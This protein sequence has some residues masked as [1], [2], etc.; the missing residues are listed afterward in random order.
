MRTII[1]AINIFFL[2]IGLSAFSQTEISYLT[3][4]DAIRI[5]H[6]QSPDALSARQ[7]L[8][9]SYWDYRS[10][11]ASN[12]PALTFNST[13]PYLNQTVSAQ[14]IDG[15]QSYASYKYSMANADLSLTQ[16]IGITGGSVSIKSGL[17][18]Q[19]NADKPNPTPYLSNPINIV[20]NQP[21]FTYNSFR[22]DRKIKPLK[23]SIAQKK[24]LEDLEQ[25]SIQTVF[26][27]FQLLQAQVELKIAKVNLSNYDTL[28]R[29]AKGRYQLGK[30][31]ENDLLQLE[32]NFLNAQ[33]QHESANLQ[34]DNA[35]YRFKS[36]LRL[37]DDRKIVLI[38]PT[39]TDFFRIEPGAAV[40]YALENS[41][42]SLDFKRRL[43]EGASA[44]NQAKMNGRFDANLYALVG[45]N[46]TAATI[47]DAY[48]KP[49]DERQLALGVTIPILDWGVARG[50]IK[51]EQSQMEIVRNSVEQDSIDFRLNVQQKAIEFNMQGNQLLIAA[52]SD[53]VARK[54]YEV[55]KGRYL[56]G[57]MNSIT[58]LNTAQ[59]ET[60][61]S[62]KNYYSNLWTYWRTYFEIRKMTLFDFVLKKPIEFDFK[63]FK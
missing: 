44:V 3:L 8:R 12:L 38:P 15:V 7:N 4:D 47:P 57:K 46:K 54:S 22:W 55:T 36:Y 56:I 61:R 26:Y 32:V 40:G 27:F 2:M 28:Y 30:I 14:S 59:T 29:I 21:L 42:T 31:A 43:L 5:S 41:S 34:V 58:D 45:L 50:K 51:V 16:K 23:Y 39:K 19:Y 62:Q 24:Y 35:Q 63:D 13:I 6:E 9:S 52:K 20:L 1:I 53:T 33:L 25:I 60:D 10:Y 37:Q 49:G 17:Q 48:V 11:Q 18:A